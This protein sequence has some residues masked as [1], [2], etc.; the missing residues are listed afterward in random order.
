MT[1]GATRSSRELLLTWNMAYK[2][3]CPGCWR[4]TDRYEVSNQ[5]TNKEERQ[6]SSSHP[7]HPTTISAQLSAKRRP[8]RIETSTTFLLILI[9]IRIQVMSP[10]ASRG[11][12]P[13]WHRNIRCVILH[14]KSRVPRNW[15]SYSTSHHHQH[16]PSIKKTRNIGIIAH[17]DAV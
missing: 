11:R 17:I 12:C 2:T 4:R 16:D 6:A 5:L 8:R 7:G 9:G 13:V 15:T 10:L 1:L 3:H 14:D